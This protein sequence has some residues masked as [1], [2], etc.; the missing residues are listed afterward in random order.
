MKYELGNLM[1]EDPQ[2]ETINLLTYRLNAVSTELA[3]VTEQRDGLR[4]A[5]DYASDKLA[6]VTEQ[7]DQ[8]KAA[9]ESADNH[10]HEI[11]TKLEIVTEQR[12][13]LAAA[14]NRISEYQGVDDEDPKTMAIE[15]LQSLN[16]P[17]P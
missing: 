12:D 6:A 14:L 2:Q 10:N 7:R 9:L 16:Q 11:A 17:T 4:S 1:A 15:A 13:R 8:Y 3:A 5:V